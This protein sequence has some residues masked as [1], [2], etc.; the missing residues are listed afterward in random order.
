MGK[1]AGQRDAEDAAFQG[2]PHSRRPADGRKSPP[3]GGFAREVREVRFC[4]DAEASYLGVEPV[5]TLGG[6]PPSNPATESRK[7]NT[8]GETAIL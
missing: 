6:P 2:Y 4:G 5:T 7:P 1:K 3:I 8:L